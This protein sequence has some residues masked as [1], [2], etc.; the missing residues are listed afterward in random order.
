M[1]PGIEGVPD[2]DKAISEAPPPPMKLKSLDTAYSEEP[3][4]SP[5]VSTPPDTP[6]PKQPEEEQPAQ[7]PAEQH[8]AKEEG[9]ELP[10]F[11]E[12]E[13][14]ELEGLRHM[15]KHI[16]KK[17]EP[18]PEPEPMPEPQ[19]EPQPEPKPMPEPEP[20][21]PPKPPVRMMKE[22][23]TDLRGYIHIMR[24]LD[25][26]RK[27][28]VSMNRMLEQHAAIVEEQEE[29]YQTLLGALN[30]LQEQFM[31]IDNKLFENPN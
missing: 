14:K 30:E 5:D 13:I 7:Q 27:A 23:F 12:Q 9:F 28:A 17:P 24:H 3:V 8:T 2:F 20:L 1:P 11:N 4:P 6:I 26:T 29:K 19:P 22:K 16:E 10:D 21:A 15:H 31:I 18:Q 25:G